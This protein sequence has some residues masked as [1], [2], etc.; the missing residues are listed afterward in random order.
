M[1]TAHLSSVSQEATR[2]TLTVQIPGMKVKV[3][4]GQVFPMPEGAI[5][6]CVP[7]R[8]HHAKVQVD[9]VLNEYSDVLVPVPPE[10][11]L[12]KLGQCKN[13]FIQW[14]KSQ[15]ILSAAASPR[16]APSSN[17]PSPSVGRSPLG[18]SQT[19]PSFKDLEDHLVGD[20]YMEPVL[21]SP[22]APEEPNNDPPERRSKAQG[23]PL[24]QRRGKI[25]SPTTLAGTVEAAMAAG[26]SPEPLHTRKKSKKRRA[27]TGEKERKEQKEMKKSLSFSTSSSKLSTRS[28]GL[29]REVFY[30]G[31]DLLPQDELDNLSEDMKALHEDYLKMSRDPQTFCQ[32]WKVKV[33]RDYN[34]FMENDQD[35]FDINFE[36]LFNMYN[37]YRLDTTMVRLWALYQ[38]QECRRLRDSNIGIID[39]ICMNEGYAATPDGRV[40]LEEYLTRAFVVHKDKEYLLAPYNPP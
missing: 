33:P 28:M 4:H 21:Q 38:A 2:C 35:T 6:H 14:P 26:K 12:T 37:L 7:M 9:L 36:D 17:N 24:D 3:A 16:T 1:R 10:A 23:D 15:I 40:F 22:E 5:L 27:G 32:Y 19:P 31:Q 30:P 11:E 29:W 34:F 25:I 13:Y 20:Q 39:P 8:E 18:L